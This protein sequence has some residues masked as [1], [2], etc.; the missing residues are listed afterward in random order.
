MSKQRYNLCIK[1][2]TYLMEAQ[3]A[4]DTGLPHIDKLMD[5]AIGHEVADR[6]HQD[7]TVDMEAVLCDILEDAMETCPVVA[8]GVGKALHDLAPERHT[9][10]G[11]D[12]VPEPQPERALGIIKL[13]HQMKQSLRNIHN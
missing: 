13:L 2:H 6:L 11:D 10:P 12:D 8:W 7:K 4:Y 9:E 3:L 1:T 5:A